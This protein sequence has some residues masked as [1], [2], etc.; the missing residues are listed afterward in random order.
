MLR[1]SSIRQEI[2]FQIPCTPYTDMTLV[3]RC[4]WKKKENHLFELELKKLKKTK[5]LGL[6]KLY[7]KI[8]DGARQ[9]SVKTKCV[10]ET[11]M[12]PMMANSKDGLDHTDKYH[13]TSR[14]I[15]PCSCV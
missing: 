6:V 12:P 8:F 1:V 3:K 7:T 13:E 5:L 2:S 4:V 15:L 14:K 9:Y 11:Q 10:C